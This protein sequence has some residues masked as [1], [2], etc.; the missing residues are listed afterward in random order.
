MV[1]QMS[2]TN[3]MKKIMIALDYDDKEKVLA[4]CNQLN[5]NLCRLKLVNNYSLSLDQVLLKIYI[6]K[7][8]KSS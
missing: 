2:Q 5:P 8:L 1:K 7:N 4:L 6:K 3:D